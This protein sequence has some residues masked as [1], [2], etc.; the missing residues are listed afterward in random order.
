MGATMGVA[1]ALS[2]TAPPV[3][4]ATGHDSAHG[5]SRIEALAGHRVPV[6]SA[7]NLALLWRPDVV[8]LLLSPLH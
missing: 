2:T 6:I 3:G 5:T 4:H 1:T 7:E 8:V